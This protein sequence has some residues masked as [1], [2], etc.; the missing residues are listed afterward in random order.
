MFTLGATFCG[1]SSM[2][3]TAQASRPWDFWAA[4]C[5]IVFAAILD[6]VDGRVAR[7]TRTES[8]FG[9]QLDSLSDAVAFGVAPAWLVYHWGLFQLGVLGVLVAFSFVAAVCIR[10]ARF[11]VISSERPSRRFFTGLPAPLGAAAIAS[12][13]AVHTHHMGH[14]HAAGA[15]QVSVAGV[16]VGVGLLMVSTIRFRSFKDLRLSRRTLLQVA[17]VLAGLTYLGVVA[18]PEVGLS[19][20]IAAYIAYHL[21]AFAVH[22]ERRLLR[23]GRGLSLDVDALALDEP[24]PDEDEDFLPG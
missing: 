22:I 17:T 14:F 9:L 4:C 10:L 13:V 12:M 7:L 5:L 3:V 1:F 6:G 11:N 8:D 16:T 18:S 23:R 15:A 21:A 19:A 20:L 2:L 24:E